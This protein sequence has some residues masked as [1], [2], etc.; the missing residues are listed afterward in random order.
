MFNSNSGRLRGCGITYLPPPSLCLSL[1]SRM[2]HEVNQRVDDSIGVVERH[3]D[4]LRHFVTHR[5]AP[6]VADH[7]RTVSQQTGHDDRRSSD[8]ETTGF[9]FISDREEHHDDVKEE[10]HNEGHDQETN[11]LVVGVLS[12]HNTSVVVWVV[13]YLNGSCSVSHGVIEEHSNN[14]QPICYEH[15]DTGL[16]GDDGGVAERKNNGYATVYSE[17]EQG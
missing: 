4:Y 6:D 12:L 15:E 1:G 8:Q 7:C 16:P 10:D 11:L 5:Y 17:R 13:L 2:C 9:S 14:G 3:R